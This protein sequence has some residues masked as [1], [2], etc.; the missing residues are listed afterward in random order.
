MLFKSECNK[1]QPKHNLHSYIKRINLKLLQLLSLHRLHHA[2]L[3]HAHTHTHTENGHQR[4]K[5]AKLMI[6]FRGWM[7]RASQVNSSSAPYGQGCHFS[8]PPK[9]WIYL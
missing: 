9:A 3:S 5:K 6:A 8:F 7:S 4:L 2:K 1:I